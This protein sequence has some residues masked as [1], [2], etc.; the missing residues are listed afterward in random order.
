MPLSEKT[1]TVLKPYFSS[2]TSTVTF[3]LA[4][5]ERPKSAWAAFS[6]SVA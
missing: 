5:L 2:L 3:A 6:I 1:A 4:F